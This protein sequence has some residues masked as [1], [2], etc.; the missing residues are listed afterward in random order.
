[1]GH[2]PDDGG[3]LPW[4]FGTQPF[5]P[6]LE[7]V[8]GIGGRLAVSLVRQYRDGVSPDARAC[9]WTMTFGSEA[10]A[11]RLYDWMCTRADRWVVWGRIAPILGQALFEQFL[12]DEA[13]RDANLLADEASRLENE[14][15]AAL[16]ITIARI[17]GQAHFGLA[18]QRA[19]EPSPFFRMILERRI[20]RD[21]IFDWL[22]WQSH[23]FHEWHEHRL[24]NGHK[25]LERMVLEGM[26]TTEHNV[27]AAGLGA[28]TRRPLKFWRGDPQVR[29]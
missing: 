3:A 5:V 13:D 14:H 25:S 20:E 24:A 12:A 2:N 1:M 21:R 27:K 8:D 18:L 7:A 4:N 23:R 22:R 9:I 11:T 28:G 19:D 6:V 10:D 15:R 16:E 29:F 17:D 26:L